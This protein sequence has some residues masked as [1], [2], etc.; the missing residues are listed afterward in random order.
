MS[1]ST[2]R[3]NISVI[4]PTFNRPQQLHETLS[5]LIQI[6]EISEIVVINDCPEV[7]IKFDHKKVQI[8]TNE[9][10]CGEATSI[11]LGFSKI[12]NRFFAI[13]SDDDPQFFDWLPTIVKQ[14]RAFPDF[15]AYYPSTRILQGGKVKEIIVAPEFNQL[16]FLKT[17][18]SY[19]LAGVVIDRGKIPNYVTDLR[20][21]GVL[22][23]NDLIQWLDLSKYGNFLAV[24]NSFANWFIH[25]GQL[26]STLL[27]D[28]KKQMF[29]KNL[30]AWSNDN[31]FKFSAYFEAAIFLRSIQFRQEGFLR[32]IFESIKAF[33][34]ILNE[35]Q[36]RWLF[37]T[38]IPKILFMLLV[39]KFK[40]SN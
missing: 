33:R 12:R 8:Y 36:N 23:P 32:N 35:S 5:S 20:P 10:R 31:P 39:M 14:I 34:H 30:M 4:V 7:E 1:T 21:D 24:P 17:L 26:T 19:C 15:I 28:Q 18:K 37:I 27:P 38:S 2:E 16:L 25:E 11:N 13:I 40:L 6:T 22:F 3:I 9:K 29:V